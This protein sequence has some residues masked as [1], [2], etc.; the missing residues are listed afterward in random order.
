MKYILI[1][2]HEGRISLDA[3]EFEA[4]SDAQNKMK[5]ELIKTFLSKYGNS[6]YNKEEVIDMISNFDSQN[7][8]YVGIDNVFGMCS[9]YATIFL[10][11]RCLSTWTILKGELAR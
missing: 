1:A 4:F 6:E 11:M 9:D 8:Y 7:D 3:E 5:E 2:L 10:G